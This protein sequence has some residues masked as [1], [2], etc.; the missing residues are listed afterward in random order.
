MAVLNNLNDQISI[1]G[2]TLPSVL[3][4]ETNDTQATVIGAGYLFPNN[5][6]ASPNF[7]FVNN[8]MALVYTTDMGANW[9]QVSITGQNATYQVSLIQQQSVIDSI[10]GTAHR[11]TASAG[12]NVVI[13]IANDYVGQTSITTLG[14]ITTV[15]GIQNALGTAAVPTYTFTGHTNLGIY[16]FDANSIGFASN[17]LPAFKVQGI[18]ASV[19]Y[20]SVRSAIT[21]VDP[22]I[23][24]IGTD[25]DINILLAPKGAGTV[26][27]LN[28]LNTS[29]SIL[30]LWDAHVT[31]FTEI[32][33]SSAPTSSITYKLPPDAPTISGQALKA[34]VSV[35]GIST[36]SWGNTNSSTWIIVGT[37]GITMTMNT[38][39]IADTSA[40]GVVL[41]MP[42][43]PAVGDMV[44]VAGITGVNSWQ[45][46]LAAGQIAYRTTGAGSNVTSAAGTI[47]SDIAHTEYYS[48]CWLL[49]FDA[50]G[51]AQKFVQI[52]GSGNPIYA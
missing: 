5:S 36:M 45:I 15:A 38:Y 50:T 4:I 6:S 35:G 19:N 23:Q 43:N 10:A 37:P 34:T 47:T 14:L 8:Q 46:Q 40:G 48:A 22:G 51:G 28:P 21:D 49:C 26:T 18:A 17:G 3:Y 2:G 25:A 20:L 52:G 9:Y 29:D 39:Y 16:E 32:S 11:I 41:T 42:N 33:S 24:A 30:Q 13:N 31:E 7:P 27:I 44:F 12:P 1:S